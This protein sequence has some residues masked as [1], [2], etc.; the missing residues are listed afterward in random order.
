MPEL[1]GGCGEIRLRSRPG[2]CAQQPAGAFERAWDEFE[3][4]QAMALE[5]TGHAQGAGF[6]RRKAET[7]VVGR[8]ADKDDRAMT[9]PP[10]R[11]ESVIDQGRANPA[12]AAIGGDSHRPQKQSRMA[13]AARDGP[14]AGRANDPLALGCD[15]SEAVGRRPPIPQALRALAPAQAAEGLVEQRFAAAMSGG[16]S[17]LIEI[18]SVCSR[19]GARPSARCEGVIFADEGSRRAGSRRCQM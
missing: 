4:E 15:E 16:R 12:I 9:A 18:I 13:R 7:A 2:G 19:P 6:F 14:Q 8:I 10:G 11:V 17:F 3:G 5:R 1:C